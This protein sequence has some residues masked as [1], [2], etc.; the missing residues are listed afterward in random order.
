VAVD[1][2]A[3]VED[4]HSVRNFD[5]GRD[6]SPEIVAKLLETAI[7]APSAGNCQPWYFF[8]VRNQEI[9]RALAQ[10]ALGQWFLSEAPVVIV[11]CAE[12]E[13]S[14]LR[15]AN[16]GRYLYCLQDT[17]AATENLLLAAVASGLGTC[18][19]GAFDDEQASQA[20]DLPAHLR[21][22]AIVPIGYP[23]GR[24]SLRTDRRRL[25]TVSKLVK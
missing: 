22:V 4:R 2:W 6:V 15:Y 9:K 8:V 13:R 12:P 7:R 24:L 18:W 10:A 3:V 14:A 1:F 16:R 21:P 17:A 20:L 25:E 5:Q 19:V 23:T 11:V